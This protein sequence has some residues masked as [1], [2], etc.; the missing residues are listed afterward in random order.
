MLK[1]CVLFLFYENCASFGEASNSLTD[2][3]EF[4]KGF[5]TNARKMPP[6]ALA[7][8]SSDFLRK[9]DLRLTKIRLA[10]EI[11][12]FSLT[13][14]PLPCYNSQSSSVVELA[15]SAKIFIVPHQNQT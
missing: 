2:S 10:N 1:I 8:K 9:S 4:P 7:Q 14:L 6:I 5:E 11:L 12:N 13:F 15:A 3:Y